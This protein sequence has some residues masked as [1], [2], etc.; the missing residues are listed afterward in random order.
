MKRQWLVGTLVGLIAVTAWFGASC[1]AK[2]DPTKPDFPNYWQTN[3]PEPAPTNTPCVVGGFTC[4]P[5][6]TRTPVCT[7]TPIAD[8]TNRFIGSFTTPTPIIGDTSWSANR[9]YGSC[10]GGSA[11][12][13]LYMFR[14]ASPASIVVSS[15]LGVG[16]DNII[17]LS[18]ACG[19]GATLPRNVNS[20]TCNDDGNCPVTGTYRQAAISAYLTAGE[21]FIFVDGWSTYQGPY[22]ILVYR[23]P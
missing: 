15:C 19:S 13:D 2:K 22:T 14:L 16:Y 21:Y 5:T 9:F 7:F 6:Y 10:G 18:D 12:E 8:I 4:T 11:R 3:V 20:L 23:V 17:Y 1:K